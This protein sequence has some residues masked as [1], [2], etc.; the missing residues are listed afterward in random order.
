MLEKHRPTPPKSLGAQ[1][2][3]GTILRQNLP[4]TISGTRPQLNH[5]E[6]LDLA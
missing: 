3:F 4:S 5:L 1:I 6:I 2:D